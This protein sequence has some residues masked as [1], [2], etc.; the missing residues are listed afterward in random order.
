MNRTNSI[1]KFHLALLTVLL[2]A[3]A[4]PPRARA[5]ET[6]EPLT[7]TEVIRLLENGVSVERVGA[8]AKQYGIAFQMK[9]DTEREIRSAG[10][11]DELIGMLK[12]LA[13][14][15][16]PVA[17]APPSPVKAAKEEPAK[18]A[19]TVDALKL[20]LIEGTEVK[21]KFAEDLSSKTAVEGDPVSFVLAQDIRVGDAV[22]VRSGVSAVGEVSHVQQAGF[23]GRPGELNVRLKYIRAGETRILLRGSKVKDVEGKTGTLGVLLAPLGL[24]KPGKHVEVK[25]GTRLTAYVDEDVRLPAAR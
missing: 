5:Q 7:K 17:P 15:E 23:M 1:K 12:A 16:P 4:W 19:V 22:V 24:L 6:R 14:S 20:L 18:T 25:E 2:C 8:L 21:L 10:G 13:P 3:T 9:E 11:N